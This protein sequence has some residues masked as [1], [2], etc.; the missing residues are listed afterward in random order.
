M[1]CCLQVPCLLHGNDALFVI[2]RDEG[3]VGQ[4]GHVLC[5]GLRQKDPVKGVLV[6]RGVLGPNERLKGI[7]VPVPDFKL[8]E[9]GLL[10]VGGK[11]PS[12]KLDFVRMNGVL[13]GNLPDG[14]GAVV[15]RVVRIQDELPRLFREAFIFCQSP[16]CSLSADRA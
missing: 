9:A 16:V 2:A 12:G 4:E 14:G 6:G 11:L 8:Q 15:D 13:D 7:D 1:G 3:V 5:L 10:T